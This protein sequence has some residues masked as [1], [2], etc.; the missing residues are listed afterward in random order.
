MAEKDLIKQEK[1]I[2]H[3]KSEG[4]GIVLTKLLKNRQERKE[5]LYIK[6]TNPAV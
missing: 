6:K 1:R 2:S 3:E 4:L 5:N